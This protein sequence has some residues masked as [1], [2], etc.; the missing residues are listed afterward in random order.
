MNFTKKCP[1]YLSNDSAMVLAVLNGVSAIFAVGGNTL[2][3]VAI[4]RKTYLQTVSNFF[5]GS[6]AAADLL[7]GLLMNPLN[8]VMNTLQAWVQFDGIWMKLQSFLWIQLTTATTFS[9]TA[10][11]FDRFLAVMMALRYKETVTS[12]K[13]F[14]IVFF[15][16]A[17]SIFFGSMTFWLPNEQ[18]TSLW[19][20]CA[21]VTVVVPLTVISFC[22][23]RM[24][25]TAFLHTRRIA[26]QNRLPTLQKQINHKRRQT[27]AT[28]TAAVIIVVF[29]FLF[30]P[31]FIINCLQILNKDR[32]RMNYYQSIW[33]WV[34]F[35]SYISSSINPWI[36]AIR[37]DE[38]RLAFKSIFMLN[39][40][41]EPSRF[42]SIFDR[43]K[44]ETT[45]GVIK[46]QGTPTQERHDTFHI[47]NCQENEAS[48]GNKYPYEVG[49]RQER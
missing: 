12:F 9:L 45:G 11:T 23:V 20:A 49:A 40:A 47:E 15:N 13:C 6:L 24:C 46:R 43:S 26:S 3:L 27:K 2:I 38:Y 18:M 29:V 39:T 31:S 37:S 35:V 42:G 44:V 30:L 48:P 5:L 28:W 14:L 17:F 1:N 19:S 4:Y 8:I 16:W 22:Y 7:V 21:F 32:C 25:K 34:S 41:G 36:Y 33:A 10:V